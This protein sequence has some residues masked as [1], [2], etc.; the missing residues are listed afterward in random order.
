MQFRFSRC[1]AVQVPDLAKAIDYYHGQLGLEIVHRDK[2]GIE[3][4]RGPGRLFLEESPL[5]GQVAEFLCD[6]LN[7]GKQYLMEAGCE[8]I[9][10]E[11]KG[12]R[13]YLKDPFGVVFN[14]F[15]ETG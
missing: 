13:C 10:W 2:Q 3:L 8:V 4:G 5:T 12:G 9:V 14:V 15:E 6:D 7:K 11:G 1:M